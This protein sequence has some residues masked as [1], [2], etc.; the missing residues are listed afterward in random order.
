MVSEDI[1]QKVAKLSRLNLTSSEIKEFSKD[2]DEVLE[3]FSILEKADISD[4]DEIN[5]HSVAKENILREDISSDKKLKDD[6]LDI[7]PHRKNDY[8]KGPRAI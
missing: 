2:F 5:L 7:S 3:H 1:I 8:F 4:V 6:A